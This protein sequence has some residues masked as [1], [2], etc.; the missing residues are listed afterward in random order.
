MLHIDILGRSS[1]NIVIISGDVADAIS[2]IVE[3]A[4]IATGNF[5]A[6]E[7]DQMGALATLDAL[8][9]APILG[10]ISQRHGGEHLGGVTAY[11]LARVGPELQE[12]EHGHVVG[13]GVGAALEPGLSQ[14]KGCGIDPFAECLRVVGGGS[15]EV[16]W[17]FRFLFSGQLFAAGFGGKGSV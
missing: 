12:D 5:G 15:G 2:E 1:S 17:Q 16:I 14:P 7:L 9:A 13:A 6:F 3:R 10:P 11:V 4:N 8:G